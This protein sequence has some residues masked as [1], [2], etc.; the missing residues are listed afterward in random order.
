MVWEH[1][2]MGGVGR[3]GHGVCG[4]TGAWGDVGRLGHG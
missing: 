2:D 1:W 3:L 4:K